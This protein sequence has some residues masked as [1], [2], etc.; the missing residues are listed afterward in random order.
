[1][2]YWS[3]EKGLFD[4]E[5]IGAGAMVNVASAMVN[6]AAVKVDYCSG[7]KGLLTRKLMV[8]R[9]DGKSGITAL[10]QLGLIS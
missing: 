5:M 4:S 2:D 1:M 3:G 9:Y 10:D 7:K 8:K 6:V